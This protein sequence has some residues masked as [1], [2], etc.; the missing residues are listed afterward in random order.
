MTDIIHSTYKWN[1]NQMFRKAFTITADADGSRLMEQHGLHVRTRWQ[2]LWQR[3]SSMKQ[4]SHAAEELGLQ[5]L[6][7]VGPLAI[8]LNLYQVTQSLCLKD[9]FPLESEHHCQFASIVYPCSNVL[10]FFLCIYYLR[11]HLLGY[12][13][14]Y[15]TNDFISGSA[16]WLSPT[17]VVGCIQ[18]HPWMHVTLGPQ[19]GHTWMN[20]HVALSP[21]NYPSLWSQFFVCFVCLFRQGVPVMPQTTEIHLPQPLQCCD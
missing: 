20:E 2:H 4:P 11:S 17:N 15:S 1:L 14:A 5:F 8:F 12:H 21:R 3:H 7:K 16:G 13:S 6:Y 18:R 10:F 9:L 19:T